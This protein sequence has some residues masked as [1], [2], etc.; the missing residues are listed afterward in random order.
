MSVQ[1]C[2]SVLHVVL[3]DVNPLVARAWRAAFHDVP[4]VEVVCGSIL[5]QSV[6]AWVTPT[7]A[8]GH[9]DGGVDATI[10]HH[11][12]AG[13]ERR[14][15]EAIGQLHGGAMPV[16]AAVCVPTGAAAPRFLIST[17]T[18]TRSAESVRGTLNV[19]LACAAAF[20]AIHAQN[21]REPDS[22]C[23][24]ALPGLGAATGRVPPKRCAR[25]MWAAYQLS[26]DAAFPD[27]GSMRAALLDRLSGGDVLPAGARV[28]IPPTPRDDIS[29]AGPERLPPG[30][31]GDGAA[32]WQAVRRGDGE[33]RF[34]R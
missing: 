29:G 24:V 16:G 22:I 9:M 3:V 11:L 30:W 4:E 1:L 17:P 25:Q 23:S 7:N 26:R 8:R 27:F 12:G 14:V 28:R 20:Q 10:K 21:A 15:Q 5:D 13:I 6:D 32:E 34:L 18:M 19:T 33:D 2:R 31:S